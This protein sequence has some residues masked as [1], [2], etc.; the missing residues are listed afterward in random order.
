MPYELPYIG[1]LA[2][3]EKRIEWN[4]SYAKLNQRW[5]HAIYSR[6]RIERKPDVI[7]LIDSSKDLYR[8]NALIASGVFRVHVIHLVKDPRAFVYSMIRHENVN[9]W[10]QTLRKTLRWHVENALAERV[11]RGLLPSERYMKVYYEDLAGK[12]EETLEKI[13]HLLRID[14]H[15][16]AVHQFRS[17]TKHDISGNPMKFEDRPIT[18]DEKW[19]TQM[20]WLS[21]WFVNFA[22]W[23]FDSGGR[24]VLNRAR[25]RLW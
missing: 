21:K 25:G 5:L 3:P 18:L 23:R 4:Q 8:C 13:W 2:L 15:P 11:Y 7:S 10:T 12:P 16:E 19:K 24:T 20:P 22:T 14:S 6:V 17:Y 1:K 9:A